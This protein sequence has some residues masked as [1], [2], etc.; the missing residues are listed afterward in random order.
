[1]ARKNV[2]K[3][4]RSSNSSPLTLGI[5]GFAVL[6]VL[7][8]V[9]RRKN[10][11]LTPVENK[12]R[13]T[14][15][16]TPNRT[17]AIKPLP[18][19]AENS[20]PSQSQVNRL[21]AK[22]ASEVR[23]G[24]RKF[25]LRGMNGK[26]SIPFAFTPRKLWCQGGDLDTMKH[27]LNGDSSSVILA[28]LGPMNG[29][30][31][32][33]TFRTNLANLFRGFTHSFEI[34]EGEEGSYGLTICSDQKGTKSCK[35]KSLMS[36]SMIADQ[37][38]AHDSGAAAQDYIFY[39]Q[40]L[41]VAKKQLYA[42]RSDEASLKYKSEI[43]NYL[44]SE[45]GLSAEALVNAWKISSTSRSSPLEVEGGKIKLS[46]PYNDPNCGKKSHPK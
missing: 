34:K 15:E 30:G 9:F 6:L 23:L 21:R 41:I 31:K 35:G 17:V 11:E 43:G 26:Y 8:F 38:A 36:H 22:E 45:A 19:Q 44:Q 42:Y 29:S 28:T 12:S 2:R 13:K 40:H 20:Q 10:P 4:P 32:G 5:A 3:N 24:V 16:V 14:T 46:L 1:M 7:Y 27:A 37:A 39:F 33:D 18:I 25:S